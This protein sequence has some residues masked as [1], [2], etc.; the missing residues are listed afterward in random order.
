MIFSFSATAQVTDE[1]LATELSCMDREQ[2][3]GFLIE[4]LGCIDERSKHKG[5]IKEFFDILKV[6]HYVNR[7]DAD[8]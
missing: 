3:M 7:Q 6:S 5:L 8:Q 2:L 4:L 1:Q